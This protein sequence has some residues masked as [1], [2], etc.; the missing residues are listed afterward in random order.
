[1]PADPGRLQSYLDGLKVDK[2]LKKQAW[3]AYYSSE[4][5]AAFQTNF[6]KI[7]IPKESKKALWDLKFS[8]EATPPG[9]LLRPGERLPPGKKPQDGR[10]LSELA[11][12]MVEGGLPAAGAGI[13]TALGPAGWLGGSVAAGLGGM[14]GKA[15][16]DIIQQ[17][18]GKTDPE[19]TSV[20]GMVEEGGKQALYEAGGRAVMG[21]VGKVIGGPL[22]RATGTAENLPIKNISREAGINLT[23]PQMADPQAG[24]AWK[25]A[26][27]LGEYSIF[28]RT[29]IDVSRNKSVQN[30]LRAIDGYLAKISPQTSPTAMGQAARSAIEESNRIFKKTAES[31][32]SDVDREAQSVMVDMRPVKD[33]ALK[34]LQ[35]NAAVKATY[36]KTGG[37][38]SKTL[39]L[40]DEAE[41]QPAF[42]PFSVAHKWRS[43]LIDL[44]PQAQQLMSGKDRGV[45]KD[46]VKYVTDSMENSAAILN[47]KAKDAWV[48]ARDFYRQG[49]ELFQASTIKALMGKQGGPEMVATAIS[50]GSVESAQQ[51]KTAILDYPRK[52]GDP[53]EKQ[54]AEKTWKTFQ[55]QF[56]RSNILRDPE[57]AGMIDTVEQLGKITDNLKRM[58][59]GVINEVFDD[60]L[61]KEVI[62]NVGH[63]G[64]AMNRISKLPAEGRKFAYDAI[65]LVSEGAIGGTLGHFSS[66]S[67][68]IGT[69]AGVAGFEG[70]PYAVT[71]ILYSP[72]ATRYFVDG[73]DGLLRYSS[74]KTAQKIGVKIEPVSDFLTSATTNRAGASIL[75]NFK[76]AFDIAEDYQNRTKESKS[77]KEPPVAGVRRPWDSPEKPIPGAPVSRNAPGWTTDERGNTVLMTP[78]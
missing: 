59:P 33:E 74:N 41:R 6:D 69:L 49:G 25:T 9:M 28:S 16:G 54:V 67:A 7:G 11:D 21:T 78:R 51:V 35:Q 5:P 76:R 45:T 14:A 77:E 31:M 42:V 29:A 53:A 57:H 73:I 55:E 38:G 43:N 40:L 65:R 18:R 50:P 10:P 63:V 37:F 61:G 62:T 70:V 56:V 52:Y 30:G 26:Q 12:A 36:P 15:T 75:A 32:Y 71:K 20:G 23:G 34:L 60:T 22:R 46:M 2:G 47:P 64:E 24:V 44:S 3:D 8:T 4:N 66:G 1:M 13:A 17:L 27:R 68:G 19:Y 39:K 72:K 58:G 48:Q